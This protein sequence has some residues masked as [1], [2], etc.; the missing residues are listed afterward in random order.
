MLTLFQVGN[1]GLD[2]SL[3]IKN[4]SFCSVNILGILR[5][6]VPIAA[7]MFGK[8]MDLLRSG[9]VKPVDPISVMPFERIEEAIATHAIRQAYG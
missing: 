6:S 8:T 4:V 2:M 1:T 3:S 7:R 9:A 5:N